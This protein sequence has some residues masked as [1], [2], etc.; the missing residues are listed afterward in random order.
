MNKK[1][2][3][4]KRLH[5]EAME[6][7][8]E[9]FV[10]QLEGN[11]K[12]YLHFT[13]LALEKEAA[14]A[15]LM[16]DED[17]EPTRSVLHRSAATLA[18]R[19]QEYE[20]AKRLAYRALAGN[21]PSQIEWEL[22]DLLSTVRLEEAGIRLGK[23]QL[24]FS[25]QGGEVGYGK[26]AISELTGRMPSISSMVQISAKSV[27]RRL[28]DISGDS[29][30]DF[31]DIPIFVDGFAPGS[32]IVSL[33]LGMPNQSE[34]PGFDRFEN[35]LEP[36]LEQL[37]L[38][39]RGEFYELQKEIQD[40]IDY[41]GFVKAARKLAPDGK[42]VNSV[43]FKASIHDQ[44][45]IVSFDLLQ[46]SLADFPL[47]DLT[48]E[49]ETLDGHQVTDSDI[50]IIGVLKVADGLVKTECVLITDE[51]AR[52][53]IEG[54]E[55]VL[56]KIVRAHFKRRVAISGKRMKKKTN[57]VNR[58][59]LVRTNDVISLGDDDPQE[60]TDIPALPLLDA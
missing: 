41:V 24:Q 42:R 25:L 2:R 39:D 20:R 26:A 35:V 58:I 22:Q 56:D 55:D 45:R 34:L 10:L 33:R 5:R 4:V 19:C 21:P 31:S 47:P 51:N 48:A 36:F 8:D 17:V 14:A 29:V 23:G 54:P 6:Y 38:V 18:W 3:E 9:A 28:S 27:Y 15:D 46:H 40:P 50:Q 57:R 1:A 37:N 53:N 7:A 59:R 49:Q 32:F 16:V 52:W 44:L 30:D 13:R 60:S 11:R 43:K 12:K